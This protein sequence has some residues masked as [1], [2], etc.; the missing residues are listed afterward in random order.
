MNLQ[1][2]I[3]AI[4][5]WE[6]GLPLAAEHARFLARA[7]DAQLQLVTSVFDSSVGAACDRGEE[8]ARKIRGRTIDAALAVLERLATPLR[9][10][11]VAVTTRVAWGAPVY[12]QILDAAEAWDADLVVVGAH[13]RATQHA[14]LTDTDWQLLGRTARP[15]LLVKSAS[16]SGY[17][18]ILI[19]VDPQYAGSASESVDAGALAAARRLAHA[20]DSRLCECDLLETLEGRTVVDAAARHDAGLLVVEAAQGRGAAAA[21]RAQTVE[22]VAGKVECDVLIVPARPLTYSKVG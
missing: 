20:F 8:E 10:S 19:A 21:M 14:R 13:D 11:G 9:E 1:K 5:P 17:E 3:L 6:R 2:V 7:D 12:Q 15:L 18:S 22:L 4:K 16:F